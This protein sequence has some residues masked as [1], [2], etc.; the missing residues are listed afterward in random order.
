MTYL[1]LKKGEEVHILLEELRNR[2]DQERAEL[3]KRAVDNVPAGKP[4]KKLPHTSNFK[5]P[6]SGYSL[7]YGASYWFT[8]KG[9]YREREPNDLDEIEKRLQTILVIISEYERQC[10][11]VIDH[12]SEVSNFNAAIHDTITSIMSGIGVR[13]SRTE[14]YRK[15]ANSV[16]THTR[17][18][19]A[20]YRD[21]LDRYAPIHYSK[22]HDADRMR[23]KAEERATELRRSFHE[24]RLQEEREAKQKE[25]VVK[26][27][28]MRVKYTPQNPTASVDEIMDTILSKNK[29]LMLYHFLVLNRNDWTEGY[30]YAASGLHGFDIVEEEDQEIYQAVMSIINGQDCVD[31]RHFR[32]NPKCIPLLS[33][34]LERDCKPLMDDY[35]K[36]QEMYEN[37]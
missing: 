37:V 11:E 2:Y 3:T 22:N 35:L 9:Y 20:G 10:T 33:S 6:D 26:L 28:F 5:I 36:V 14:T 23:K 18:I 24:K 17:T 27:A 19:R 1:N 34:I 25:D 31:G 15:R 7:A 12:N 8:F 30:N 16:K 13:S 4:M 32:D 21:D 29:Y